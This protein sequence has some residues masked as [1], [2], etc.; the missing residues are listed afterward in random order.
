MVLVR[1][2]LD[3]AECADEIDLAR[4]RRSLALLVECESMLW[5]VERDA[6]A[7][8]V[9]CALGIMETCKRKMLGLR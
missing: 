4:L 3:A 5:D 8:N 6:Q 7:S 9:V 2:V 1:C